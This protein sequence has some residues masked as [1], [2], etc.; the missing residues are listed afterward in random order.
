MKKNETKF[1]SPPSGAGGLVIINYGAGNIQSIM[2]AIERLGFKATLSN[3]PDEIQAADKVIFPG[4]GEASSAM[5]KLIESGLDRL[6][7]NL[8][9]P[10]LGI[11]LGMQLMCKTS[12]EGNTKGL[13]I[14]D[15]DVIKFTPSVKVPQMGWNNIYNLQSPLFAGINENEYM[16]LVHSFYAPL[17]KEAIA[18]TNYEVEYASALQKNNFY[19]T[20]FHPEKS[21][22]IGEQ[23][24]E[25]FLKIPLAPKGGTSKR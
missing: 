20:Q 1:T 5:E 22:D 13:G 10:V 19:G 12:E 14:F 25:N 11:C 24:L 6:I 21:G 3:N 8:Q 2:F 4:V 9:Q 7:P 15:V 18:T 23:I 17:C 16:Y